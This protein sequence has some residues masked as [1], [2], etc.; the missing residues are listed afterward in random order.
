VPLLNLLIVSV[1]DRIAGLSA[2]LAHLN[3]KDVF[4][5]ISHQV[6]QALGQAAQDEVSALNQASNVNYLPLNSVGVARNRNN[7]LRNR[8]RG[9]D[10]ICLICDDDTGFYPTTYD[11]IISAF[12]DWPY[13]DVITF[14]IAKSDHTP[15]KNYPATARPHT[16]RSLTAFGTIEMAFKSD[17][18]D[19]VEVVF[20]EQFGPRSQFLIGEDY[21][22]AMDLLKRSVK[23]MFVPKSIV[24]HPDEETTGAKVDQA[25]LIGRGAMFARIFGWQSPVVCLAFIFR[26]RKTLTKQS[27]LISSLF[28]MFKGILQF[29]RSK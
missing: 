24:I 10:I 17:V 25:H 18:L 27:S 14:Q 2:R 4:F 12:S 15:F 11:S 19:K 13:V 23:M 21:I 3:R 1:D 8:L 5:T 7:A 26:K 22:F 28:Y 16:W 20:D 9:K 6:T 29:Y